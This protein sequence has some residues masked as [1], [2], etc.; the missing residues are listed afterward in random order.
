MKNRMRKNYL[1]VGGYAGGQAQYARVPFANL[2]PLKIESDLPD[3][4]VLFPLRYLSD[5]V[6]HHDEDGSD[7]HA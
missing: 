4:K 2:S 6:R 1:L 3:E 5:W 7:Q